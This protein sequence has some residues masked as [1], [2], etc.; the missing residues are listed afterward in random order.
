MAHSKPPQQQ[1]GQLLGAY[2]RRPRRPP[3][4]RVLSV[5]MGVTSSANRR[6]QWTN[7]PSEIAAHEGWGRVHAWLDVCMGMG[8]AL[9]CAPT[10]ATR[11]L[12]VR[13]SCSWVPLVL[14]GC[15]CWPSTGLHLAVPVLSCPSILCSTEPNGGGAWKSC[16]PHAAPAASG[17]APGPVLTDS[18][19]EHARPSSCVWEFPHTAPRD[20]PP[21][22]RFCIMA[23][24][25]SF[26]HSGL[27]ARRKLLRQPP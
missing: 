14:P 26:F 17:H 18:C 10:A 22:P 27:L 5:G 8:V 3:L 20:L 9:R 11:M 7:M 12:L 13:L 15:K 16:A 24:S 1:R 2:R 21:A 4:R 25:C 19:C 6:G 23:C